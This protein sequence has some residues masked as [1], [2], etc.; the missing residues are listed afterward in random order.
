LGRY[1]L[2]VNLDVQRT[3]DK[4]EGGNRGFGVE[5]TKT[6]QQRRVGGHRKKEIKQESARRG[7]VQDGAG[8]NGGE[9]PGG[10]C[11]RDL[12]KSSRGDF[13]NGQGASTDGK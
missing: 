7:T 10:G 8:G 4:G 6:Q 1:S 5:R 3:Y 12:K 13:A 11:R 2:R 9:T